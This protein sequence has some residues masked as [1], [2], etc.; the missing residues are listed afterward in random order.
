MAPADF[1]RRERAR[2]FG[3]FLILYLCGYEVVALKIEDMAPGSE[4]AQMVRPLS[5]WAHVHRHNPT[6]WGVI[7]VLATWL[8]FH[9]LWE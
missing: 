8:V 7:G 1:L 6:A 3:R 9:L 4:L 5:H 2:D